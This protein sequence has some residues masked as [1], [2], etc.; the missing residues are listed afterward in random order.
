MHIIQF[1]KSICMQVQACLLA[2]SFLLLSL[3]AADIGHFR[4]LS[5]MVISVTGDLILTSPINF[6]NCINVEVG[7]HWA[8]VFNFECIKPKARLE[9]FSFTT[10]KGS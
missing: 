1:Q 9:V 10:R 3:Y 8:T 2:F 6:L 4:L 7:K 5:P